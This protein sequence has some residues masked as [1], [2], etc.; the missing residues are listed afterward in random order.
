MISPAL[1]GV[2][3]EASVYAPGSIGALIAGTGVLVMV[4]FPPDRLIVSTDK[5]KD[6]W[7]FCGGNVKYWRISNEPIVKEEFRGS[8]Q[9]QVFLWE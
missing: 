9:D 3:Q 6:K 5:K 7:S 4:L 8:V 1:G 2:A